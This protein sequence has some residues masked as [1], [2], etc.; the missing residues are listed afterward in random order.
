MN[1]IVDYIAKSKQ[2][3]PGTKI[4][5][6]S[7]TIH[8]TSNPKSTS[9]NERSWLSNPNNTASASWHIV[10]DEKEAIEA[11]PLNEKAYHSGTAEGNAT[12]IGIELCESGD[13]A[14]VWKNAVELVA[15][16]L[17]ERNWTVK[18]LRTHKSWSGKN[19][20]RLILPMWAQFVG[21]VDSRLYELRNPPKTPPNAPEQ[22]A[23]VSGFA[24][25]AVEWAKTKNISDGSRLRDNC[26]REEVLTM[27]YRAVGGGK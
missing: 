19:C 17:F 10:V 21:E 9:R 26:T 12:S 2:K 4:V 25:E 16:M 11:I 24:R 14:K 20:P 1:Y 6:S 7:I 18:N 22:Q 15:K 5:P 8:N 27:L 13:Q 3:R 23:E